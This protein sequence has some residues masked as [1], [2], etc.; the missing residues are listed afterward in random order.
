MKKYVLHPIWGQCKFLMPCMALCHVNGPNLAFLCH[1]FKALLCDELFVS[2]VL[3]W[4]C[5][6]EHIK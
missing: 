1:V 2:Q 6:G 5:Y 4:A 3:T